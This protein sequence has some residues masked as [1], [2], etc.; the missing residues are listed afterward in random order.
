M[1]KLDRRF[2]GL[3]DV[4]HKAMVNTDHSSCSAK[5]KQQYGSSCENKHPK[6]QRAFNS[7]QLDYFS[8][9]G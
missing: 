4:C 2:T 3:C 6:K 5:R 8:R 7:R 1:T 9:L